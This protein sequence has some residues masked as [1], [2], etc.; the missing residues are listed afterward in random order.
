MLLKVTKNK[1]LH[2]L[3]IVYFSKY[4]F[5]VKTWIFFE[6]NFNII[7]C[8]MSSI[9]FY[10]NKNKLRKDCQEKHLVRLSY[11]FSSL[12]SEEMRSNA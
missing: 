2:P 7:F 12:P 9:S 4:I 10:L 6:L 3:Q 11:V 1:A 8:Q 5:R